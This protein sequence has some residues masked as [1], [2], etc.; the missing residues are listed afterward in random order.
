MTYWISIWLLLAAFL[1]VLLRRWADENRWARYRHGAKVKRKLGPRS[2]SLAWVAIHAGPFIPALFGI[3]L[4]YRPQALPT[5]PHDRLVVSPPSA[6]P[7]VVPPVIGE[8]IPQ[9]VLELY[10]AA[11]DDANV[12]RWAEQASGFG[13]RTITGSGEDPPRTDLPPGV[14]FYPLGASEME[15][16]RHRTMAERMRD[17]VRVADGRGIILAGA[18]EQA[19]Y[20]LRLP[21]ADPVQL[22]IACDADFTAR[23]VPIVT[24]AMDGFALRYTYKFSDVGRR[25][26]LPSCGVVRYG[27]TAL[28]PSA[29]SLALLLRDA[30]GLTGISVAGAAEPGIEGLAVNLEWS[31]NGRFMAFAW[32]LLDKLESEPP[33]LESL[34]TLF[35][36]PAWRDALPWL[37]RNAMPGRSAMVSRHDDYW[38]DWFHRFRGPYALDVGLRGETG[39]TNDSDVPVDEVFVLVCAE[40]QNAW[41]V[42]EAIARAAISTDAP[43]TAEEETP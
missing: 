43:R 26:Y 19:A 39:A 38:T 31:K 27:E 17:V 34:E 4:L 7:P 15:S 35:A 36:D 16:L 30:L 33:A 22:S 6:V 24:R 11:V 28:R 5:Q 21:P 14:L 13:F 23:G 32:E 18:S 25:R 2:W 29:E 9:P 40:D 41:S 1:W 10:G 12:R 3:L 42:K 20:R 8:P 37:H